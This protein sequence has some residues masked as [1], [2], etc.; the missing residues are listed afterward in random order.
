MLDWVFQNSGNSDSNNFF[1]GV[2][3]KPLWHSKRPLFLFPSNR[4]PDVKLK[5]LR[6]QL[7]VKQNWFN[8]CNRLSTLTDADIKLKI[9]SKCNICTVRMVVFN[10]FWDMK[11]IW[12][13]SWKIALVGLEVGAKIYDPYLVYLYSIVTDDQQWVCLQA[14]KKVSFTK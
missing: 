13:A 1:S 3:L 12:F 5:D 2:T 9:I 8:H 6:D 10:R 11:E 4:I 14:E 7:P